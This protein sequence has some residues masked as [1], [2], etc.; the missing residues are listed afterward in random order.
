[1]NEIFRCPD[2]G[3]DTWIATFNV[4]ATEP[5]RLT[6]NDEGDGVNEESLGAG[7]EYGKPQTTDYYNC[8]GCGYMI[9]AGDINADFITYAAEQNTEQ[10]AEQNTA[11][12]DGS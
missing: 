10:D 9:E 8:S 6:V 7:W 4:R 11:P 2:C 12:G 5:V 1:M 3:G